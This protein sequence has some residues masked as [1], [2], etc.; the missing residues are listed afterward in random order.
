MNADAAEAQAQPVFAER[1]LWPGGHSRQDALSG[2]PH[3]VLYGL[4]DVPRWILFLEDDRERSKRCLP[5]AATDGNRIVT[6]KTSVGE[7]EK[8]ALRNVDDQPIAVAIGPKQRLWD[9]VP[10]VDDDDV[11]GPERRFER[12]PVAVGQHGRRDALAG[13]DRRPRLAGNGNM[14]PLGAD[15]WRTRRGVLRPGAAEC[16]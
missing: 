15:Q 9:D 7:H 2:T 16:R 5:V 4:G 1:I 14:N 12:S 6:L 13:T 8:Q 11:A 10:V 3:L